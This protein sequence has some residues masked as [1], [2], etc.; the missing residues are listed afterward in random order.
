MYSMYELKY[1]PEHLI[2]QLFV[3]SSAT[4]YSN[5]HGGLMSWMDNRNSN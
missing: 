4:I 3:H 1:L 2:V 5:K